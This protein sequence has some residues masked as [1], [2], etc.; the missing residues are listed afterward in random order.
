M[1]PAQV[2][3]DI[4]TLI[5]VLFDDR[6]AIDGNPVLLLESPGESLVTWSNEATLS[7][8]FDRYSTWD[9]YVETIRRRWFS[10][11]LWD[12]AFLQCS[13]SFA[14]H[15]LVKHRLC[16]FPCPIRF[17]ET[18]ASRMSIEELLALL[19]DHELRERI[20]LEGPIRFDFDEDAGSDAHP[21]VHLTIWA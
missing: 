13:Y 20:R 8:L 3:N 18:D 12:G 11:A 14:G 17:S 7:E 2:R 1:T 4:D 9:E 5:T 19:D 10:V 6:L 15:R 16:Y 21:P